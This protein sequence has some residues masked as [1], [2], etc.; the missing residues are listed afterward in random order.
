MAKRE[1][2]STSDKSS[3]RE[4]NII[5]LVAGIIVALS[6]VSQAFDVDLTG[7]AVRSAS[8]TPRVLSSAD[9]AKGITFNQKSNLI[10]LP[11]SFSG[12]RY[13]FAFQNIISEIKS[14][15]GYTS[16]GDKKIW[17]PETNENYKKIRD[18]QR[19]GK[20][21]R[22][23]LA[24]TMNIIFKSASKKHPVVWKP[25]PLLIDESICGNG[26]L[27]DKEECE[28]PDWRCPRISRPEDEMNTRKAGSCSKP[29]CRCISG[30]PPTQTRRPG[31]PSSP[32]G[33]NPGERGV[34]TGDGQDREPSSI[35]YG[36][37]PGPLNW[38]GG[39]NCNTQSIPLKPDGTPQPG[40]PQ[41]YCAVANDCPPD[42]PICKAGSGSCGCQNAEGGWM[43]GSSQNP[44]PGNPD[45]RGTSSG[46]GG[47]AK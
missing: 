29:T 19:K 31:G 30:G 33:E 2:T 12:K 46:G 6:L 36:G 39:Q 37:G 20:F 17:Y 42:Y 8:A 44:E 25:S 10:T 38:G 35:T 28:S 14:V 3:E 7:E 43:P 16:S 21:E 22:K 4:G 18:A 47:P 41:A 13:D 11:Y 15:E 40:D 26:I 27:E 45:Y 32:A 24:P 23:I 9:L 1:I 5:L 34:L